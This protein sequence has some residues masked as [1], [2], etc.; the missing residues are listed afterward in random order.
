MRRSLFAALFG[1]VLIFGN[2][3]VSRAQEVVIVG[4]E[5]V[6]TAY[7]GPCGAGRIDNPSGDQPAGCPVAAA[8]SAGDGYTASPDAASYGYAGGQIFPG[9][10]SLPYTSGA[11]GSPQYVNGYMTSAGVYVPGYYRTAADSTTANNYST[12]GNVNPFTGAPGTRS[13]AAPSSGGRRR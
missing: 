13:P 8:P 1:C 11:T 10:A 2:A 5:Y 6:G 7:F 4:A 12:R 3:A 9:T